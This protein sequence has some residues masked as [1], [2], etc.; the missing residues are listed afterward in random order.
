VFALALAFV[1]APCSGAAGS[2]AHP[3]PNKA[4]VATVPMIKA[5][6]FIAIFY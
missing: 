3:A 6:F 2:W 5:N 1:A 4:T